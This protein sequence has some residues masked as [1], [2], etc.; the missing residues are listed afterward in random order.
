MNEWVFGKRWLSIWWKLNVSS[1]VWLESRLI[2]ECT[3]VFWFSACG[4]SEDCCLNVHWVAIWWWSVPIPWDGESIVVYLAAYLL[5][6]K[7]SAGAACGGGL[8]LHVVSG[9]LK[10]FWLFWVD[11]KEFVFL[12][13]KLKS[14]WQWSAFSEFCWFWLKALG[15][16]HQI[17]WVVFFFYSIFI[18]HNINGTYRSEIVLED[19]T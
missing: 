4:R 18:H 17:P 8:S 6:C 13:S 16:A 5:V 12:A 19:A 1:F 7:V 10:L 14:H 15:F 3:C 9:F 2:F 11:L